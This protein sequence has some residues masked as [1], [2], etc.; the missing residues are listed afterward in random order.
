MVRVLGGCNDRLGCL[1]CLLILGFKR[2]VAKLFYSSPRLVLKN[3]IYPLLVFFCMC[4]SC[5][6]SLIY[7]G[8]LFL[9]YEENRVEKHIG[10]SK[11]IKTGHERLF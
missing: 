11:F 7:C 6:A 3:K 1:L 8:L 4:S 9:N 10:N 5:A 2:S